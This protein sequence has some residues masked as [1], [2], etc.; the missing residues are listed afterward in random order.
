MSVVSKPLERIVAL[1]FT[2]IRRIGWAP[3]SSSLHLPV[4]SID[5][6]SDC[7]LQSTVR[8]SGGCRWRRNCRPDSVGSVGSHPMMVVR[9]CR[10]FEIGNTVLR[11]YESFFA[12]RKEY[13][14]CGDDEVCNASRDITRPREVGNFTDS[15]SQVRR[16]P[17]RTRSTSSLMPHPML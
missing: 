6:E 11:W 14:C 1:Q 16:R 13:V 4:I 5:E 10:S 2:P 3:A 8:R 17:G 15:V 9:L 7:R 12:D